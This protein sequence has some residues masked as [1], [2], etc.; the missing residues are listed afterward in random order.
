MSRFD[1]VSE[2]YIF[3]PLTKEDVNGA[4]AVVQEAEL[5][6]GSRAATL[7]QWFDVASN[8]TG[9]YSSQPYL[10]TLASLIWHR[11]QGGFQAYLQGVLQLN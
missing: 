11:L 9:Y 1:E 5:L 2:N 4:G 7:D 8:R 6:R 3:L 10:A